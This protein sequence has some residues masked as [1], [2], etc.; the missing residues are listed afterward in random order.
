MF[1]VLTRVLLWLLVLVIFFY[2]FFRI[3]PKAYFTFLGGLLLAVFVV[4][5]F[6][7]P[8]DRTATT[9]WGILS[10]PFK[11]LGIVWLLLA[12]AL[13]GCKNGSISRSAQNEIR[14]AFILLWLFSTPFLWQWI[15]HNSVERQ[16][17]ALARI[18]QT[19]TAETL[20]LLAHNT[21]EPQVEGRSQL[22]LGDRGN[23]ILYANQLYQAG[24]ITRIVVSG[25]NR[26]EFPS[27]DPQSDDVARSTNEAEL[28][29]EL[30]SRLGVPQ[31]SIL[32]DSNSPNLRRSV[33]GV[34]EL[35][36]ENN[37]DPP[38]LLVGR[39]LSMYRSASSFVQGGI[40]VIPRPTDYV[41][42]VDPD[43]TRDPVFTLEAIMP[44]HQGLTLSTQLSDE[45]LLTI[46]YFL[47]GWLSPTELTC[48]ECQPA[49][50]K[51][52]ST[53]SGP[54]LATDEFPR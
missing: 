36:A 19:Q 53:S 52:P 5:L 17:S 25:G 41:S 51:L 10:L 54:L 4:L 2:V 28:A 46:Y 39:A 23:L 27:P 31:T 49:A 1:L 6:V 13:R 37:I 44:S 16:I 50:M 43:Q 11:P 18:T 9:A 21:V 22:Q 12:Q 45:Y 30:L 15:Y 47:R 14:S 26:L 34:R 48:L 7:D 33:L 32:V 3:V 40:A 42:F 20:V 38:I 24:G 29:A 8:T 35:L